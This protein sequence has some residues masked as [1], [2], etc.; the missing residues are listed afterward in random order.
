[1]NE[2]SADNKQIGENRPAADFDFRKSLKPTPHFPI[3]DYLRVER[4][5][6]RPM[7]A[8]VVKVIWNTRITPNQVT[9]F[10]FIIGVTAA[11]CFLQGTPRSFMFAGI[12]TILSSVFDCADGML[13]RSK[14][15]QSRY[16]AYLDLF[17]DRINDFLLFGSATAG[18]YLYS[19]NLRLLILGAVSVA[20]YFL[21]VTLYYLVREYNPDRGQGASAEPRGFTLFVFS[22]F[23][24][25]NRLDIF[26]YVCVIEVFANIIYRIIK[27]SRMRPQ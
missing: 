16:G 2:K 27:F 26:L 3:L 12:L 20:L 15:Q 21:Q 11:T 13:A 1:M 4:Y 10:S 18:Y 5:I 19:G 23:A 22:L 7:A 9:V 6:T 14:N 8:V 25:L 24:I 17:L